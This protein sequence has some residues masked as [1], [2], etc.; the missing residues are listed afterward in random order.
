MAKQAKYSMGSTV[1]AVADTRHGVMNPQR[2]NLGR[3]GE[4]VDMAVLH[5]SWSY[6]VLFTGSEGISN[7]DWMDEECLQWSR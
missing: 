5:G 6:A 7:T 2:Y 4:V 1:R 3:T